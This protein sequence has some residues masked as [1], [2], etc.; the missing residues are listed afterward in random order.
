MKYSQLGIHPVPLSLRLIGRTPGLVG[1]TSRITDRLVVCTTSFKELGTCPMHVW[2]SSVWYI[3]G[4][5]P[6]LRVG[7]VQLNNMLFVY[8]YTFILLPI[9]L[10]ASKLNQHSYIPPSSEGGLHPEFDRYVRGG[11][12]LHQQAG[13]W[14]KW[15]SAIAWHYDSLKVW[16]HDSV[17]VCQCG[18]VTVWLCDSAVLQ[19]DSVSVWRY[20][21][22]T[23]W[24]CD[25]VPMWYSDS[26]RVWLCKSLKSVIV[27]QF[28]GM[29]VWQHNSVTMC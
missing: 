26:V 21:S 3:V 25:S 14:D 12:D 2:Q 29:E 10:F 13:G 1:R 24:Q 9:H 17:T 18:N 19:C 20:D 23:V 16:H 8:V 27:W 7:T 28:N 11:R 6:K 4:H 15:E 5:V 22:V